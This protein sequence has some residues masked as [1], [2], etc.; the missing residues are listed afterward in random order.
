MIKTVRRKK[1]ENTRR[2]VSTPW[3]AFFHVRRGL[4]LELQ[5]YLI[6]RHLLDVVSHKS[7]GI[8]QQWLVPPLFKLKL[9]VTFAVA[10]IYAV[11]VGCTLASR[12][13]ICG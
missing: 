3:Q 13:N 4:R 2:R 9:H 7:V 12:S 5:V 10:M 6:E 1:K 8:R 11:C